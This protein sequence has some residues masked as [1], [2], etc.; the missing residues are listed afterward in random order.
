MS[1][2]TRRQ[3]SPCPLLLCVTDVT[4]CD[5]VSYQ[6]ADHTEIQS[7]YEK[8]T[9]YQYFWTTYFYNVSERDDC[10]KT[11]YISWWNWAHQVVGVTSIR[12]LEGPLYYFLFIII[13]PP[14]SPALTAE[15]NFW[16]SA[17]FE[18]KTKKTWQNNP[19]WKILIPWTKNG[20]KRLLKSSQLG[21]AWWGQRKP[22]W[23]ICSVF[24][25]FQQNV[26]QHF[27]RSRSL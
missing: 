24:R 6:L 27:R 7:L 20:T 16:H 22:C 8:E 2:V 5:K 11:I 10:D 18:Q 17:A 25:Q 26:I 3:V 1:R 12:G 21:P 23:Y 13:T 19:P 9:S 4:I 14:P 15:V